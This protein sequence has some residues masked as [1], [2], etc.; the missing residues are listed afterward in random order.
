VKILRLHLFGFGNLGGLDL[1]PSPGFNLISG[2]N[3]SC[4]TT[5]L[6]AISAMFY[7][8]FYSDRMRLEEKEQRDR[9][10][11]WGNRQFG[12]KLDYELDDGRRFTVERIFAPERE[13]TRVI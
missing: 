6:A 1:E 11:P 12:G 8:F 2:P 5:L 9:F 13:T 3:E 7:G 4:K 10:I